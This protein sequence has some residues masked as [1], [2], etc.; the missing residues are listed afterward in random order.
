MLGDPGRGPAV[1]ASEGGSP[2]WVIR[3]ESKRAER[4]VGEAGSH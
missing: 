4:D 3:Q 1:R 2:G